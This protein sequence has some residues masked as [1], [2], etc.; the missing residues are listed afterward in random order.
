MEKYFQEQLARIDRLMAIVS[1]PDPYQLIGAISFY[2]IAIFT[3]QSM[4]HLKDWIL[5]DEEFRAKDKSALKSEI[6]ATRSLKICA[7]L[8]NGSKH[9]VLRKP[10][11]DFSFTERSGI[12]V[13][14]AKQ[15]FQEYYYI[16]SSDKQDSYHLMEI[17]EFL[18]ECRN[19]WQEIIDRHYLSEI[20]I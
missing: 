10:Q 19:A 9:L 20:D 5:N 4:W 11:T 7:D 8:A 17:R 3:C 16:A 2:D 6:H 18:A 14:P 1:A 12:H 13:D 15:I